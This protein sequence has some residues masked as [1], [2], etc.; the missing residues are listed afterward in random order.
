MD[1][2]GLLL[3][4]SGHTVG[5]RV[6][7]TGSVHDQAIIGETL[8]GEA[9]AGGV[10]R[11]LR[12]KSLDALSRETGR[13]AAVLSGWRDEFLEGGVT[14]VQNSAQTFGGFTSFRVPLTRQLDLGARGRLFFTTLPV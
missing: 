2:A 14:F 13:P 9:Q 7:A 11:L 3:E 6:R 8:V 5:R 4:Y 12:G 10:L 1:H